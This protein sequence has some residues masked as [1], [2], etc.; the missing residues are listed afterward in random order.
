MGFLPMAA[1]WAFGEGIGRRMAI[2]RLWGEVFVGRPVMI[3]N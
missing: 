1:P 2:R 3:S